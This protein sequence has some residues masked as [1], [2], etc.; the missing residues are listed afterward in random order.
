MA[1]PTPESFE[2]QS[3]YDLV[4]VGSGGGGMCAALAAKSAGLS[5]VVLEKRH[6]IGGS[7]GFSGGLWWVPNNS[8]TKR[9]GV[10]DSAELG[11]TYMDAVIDFHGKGSNDSRRAAF[12][13]QSPKMV[14]FLEREGMKFYY[15]DG[16]ADY[17]DDRAGGQS[18][19]RSIMADPYDLND[20]GSWKDRVSLY[21]PSRGLPLGSSELVQMFMFKRSL[22]A[23]RILLKLAG[24]MAINKLRGRNVVASGGAI[25]SRM[26]ALALERNIPV[27][28]DC[29]VQRLVEEDGR[30]AGVEGERDGKRFSVRARH[31]VLVNSG[32]FA[33]NDAM[34]QK[35]Q[36]HPISAKWTNA[37]PGDT[38]EVLEEMMR[39]GAD[40]ENLDLSVWIVTSLNAD[41]SA[42][43]G[44]TGKD[45]IVYPFM[46]NADISSPHL[47]IVD[48]TG[49]RYMNEAQSYVEMGETMYERD[50][51]NGKTIPSW[52]IFD[53]RHMKRYFWGPIAPGAKPIKRWLETG[54]LI[55]ANS[56]SEL[57]GKTGI[58][59]AGLAATVKRFNG[60]A[61]DG[62]DQDYGKGGRAYDLWRGD[63]SHRPNPCLGEI[64]KAPFYAIRL[65]P[66]DVGTYGGVVTDEKARVLRADGSIIPGL[67]AA[68][69]CTSSVM[70]RSYPGAGASIAASFAFGF[71]AAQDVAAR[72]TNR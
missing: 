64:S 5:A 60:F 45:G 35:L 9:A 11:R 71:I 59:E 6:V 49:H 58:D 25:Q 33:R 55:Q 41:G 38:G 67:Y 7:T 54:F 23:F 1:L 52:A 15:A 47:M 42:P 10:E 63:P 34:R 19:G 37:N 4:I 56:I 40:T 17:Y 43:V 57:A 62:V 36:R 2:L 53:R 32:G 65:F 50:A 51:L 8:V 13:E 18:R 46:H 16:W 39:I 68:G 29:H 20:L 44:A 26:L 61:R 24:K 14:D 27:F 21:G 28:T 70:G 12:I 72:A 3:E 22:K 66:S 31:G 69:N 48:R 30:I